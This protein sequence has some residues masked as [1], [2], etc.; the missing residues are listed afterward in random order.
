MLGVWFGVVVGVCVCFM[1]FGVVHIWVCCFRGLFC[2]LYEYLLDGCIVCFV[3]DVGFT[4]V[5]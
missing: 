4:W 5:V 2:F 1:W 3:L